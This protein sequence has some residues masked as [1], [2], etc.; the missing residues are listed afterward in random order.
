MLRGLAYNVAQEI[1]VFVIDDLRNFLFG[2]P[3]SGGFDLPSLNIQRGRDHG[4]PSYNEARRRMGLKTVTS[5]AE[6]SSNPEVQARLRSVYDSVEDI[7]LW[8]GGLAE[9]HVP[10]ALVGETVHTVLKDQFERL[11]DG[12]RFW[13]QIS[14]PRDL[15]KEVEKQTL[16]TI[17][18]RNSEIDREIQDD[19]FFVSDKNHRGRKGRTLT[20][21]RAHPQRIAIRP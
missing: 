6:L 14:V 4:L 18:R 3:G 8:V 7:D 19:V 16:A 20:S 10:G 9:D 11:R 12:D 2:A 17:I 15:L 5:F 21:R 1:D 13:Y